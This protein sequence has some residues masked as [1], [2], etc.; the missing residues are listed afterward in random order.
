MCIGWGVDFLEVDI[1]TSRDGVP[2]LFH[3][4]GLSRTT[5][6]TG[7]IYEL[8]SQELDRLDAGS[9]FG[10]R[11]RHERIPRLEEF[12]EWVDHRIRL[13]F[14]VKWA[15]LPAL[16]DTIRRHGVEDE[17]F[18]WFGRE[19]F[20]RAFRR[21]DAAIPLKIN[22]ST[23]EEV[24]RAKTGY[25]ASIVEFSLEQATE[26]MIDACRRNGIRSMI[27]T[28][29]NDPQVFEKILRSEV[30]MVNLDHGDHFLGFLDDFRNH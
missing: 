14:D 13:F 4:P 11:Y 24:S 7:R 9:W 27:L 28:R 21:L 5:N 18:F 19:K 2:Y 26:E 30:D 8:D 1:N 3:G 29:E 6:G 22:V 25:G 17:C 20:A 16:L 12:L 23:P 15:D 10:D